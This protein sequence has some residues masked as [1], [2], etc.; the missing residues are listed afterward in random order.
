ME[1]GVTWWE[2]LSWDWDVMIG[3]WSEIKSGTLQNTYEMLLTWS[4]WSHVWK[5]C[6][7]HHTCAWNVS[8]GNMAG[9]WFLSFQC[10]W[11][12]LTRFQGPSPPVI[13]Q[14][15]FHRIILQCSPLAWRCDKESTKLTLNNSAKRSNE[16]ILRSHKSI[17][18]VFKISTCQSNWTLTFNRSWSQWLFRDS[19]WEWDH[20]QRN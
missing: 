8:C 18:K 12:V 2:H 1:C 19:G 5:M 17:L 9:K 6:Q 10:S 7:G 3:C 20:K 11:H 16:G 14:W 15:E 13:V 4:W